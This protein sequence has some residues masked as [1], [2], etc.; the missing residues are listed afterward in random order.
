MPPGEV[1]A[2]G[3][4]VASVKVTRKGSVLT[5]HTKEGG[6]IRV[7]LRWRKNCDWNIKLSIESVVLKVRTDP[8][9]A[10]VP[11]LNV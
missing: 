11:M 8:F 9:L 6:L 4:L 1:G 5:I 2:E 10:A 7:G 3:T